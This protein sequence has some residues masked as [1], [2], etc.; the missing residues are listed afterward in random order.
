MAI[1][2]GMYILKKKRIKMTT[3]LK[4]NIKYP[5]YRNLSFSVQTS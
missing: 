4:M 2:L 5:C 1:N 3:L